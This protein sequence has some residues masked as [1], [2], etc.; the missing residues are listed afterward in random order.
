MAL[1]VSV[2]TGLTVIEKE[3][4]LIAKAIS[5]WRH[6]GEDAVNNRLSRYKISPTVSKGRVALVQVFKL[7]LPR[8]LGRAKQ[9]LRIRDFGTVLCP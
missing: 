4:L 3:V 6:L 9:S 5:P 7:F 1:S 2:L 8:P